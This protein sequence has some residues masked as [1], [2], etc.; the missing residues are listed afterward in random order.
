MKFDSCIELN[1]DYY[2]FLMNIKCHLLGFKINLNPLN[3]R[4]TSTN[5]IGV[6]LN[7]VYRYSQICRRMSANHFYV[8]DLTKKIKSGFLERKIPI[9]RYLH[10]L[11]H[12]LN[13]ETRKYVSTY[14][15][16]S[17]ICNY[18]K[19]WKNIENKIDLV[20]V[21]IVKIVTISHQTLNIHK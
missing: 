6:Y 3:E 4:F 13:N 16:I 9:I 19:I 17:K 14:I 11:Q 21:R 2:F 12:S 8:I 18:I 7:C 10:L 1:N 20:F 5:V 15:Q